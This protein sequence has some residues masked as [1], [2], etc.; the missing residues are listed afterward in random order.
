MIILLF[1]VFCLFLLYIFYSCLKVWLFFKVVHFKRVNTVSSFNSLS[2][3]GYDL[4]SWKTKMEKNRFSLSVSKK[5]I[6]NGNIIYGDSSK[7]VVMLHGFDQCRYDMIPY[8]NYFYQNNFSIVFFDFRRCGES[9][10]MSYSLGGIELSDFKQVMEFVNQKFPLLQDLYLCGH[11]LGAAVAAIYAPHDLRVK[12]LV[13]DTLYSSARELL[14]S[15]IIN[16]PLASSVVNRIVSDIGELLAI[17][18]GFSIQDINPKYSLAR[19]TMPCL[20]IHRDADLSILPSMAVSVYQKRYQIAPTKLFFLKQPQ[21]TS[22]SLEQEQRFFKVLDDFFCE[23]W[24]KKS[25]S[26]IIQ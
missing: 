12:A 19:T 11:S 24:K 14:R 25:F 15:Y 18:P 10:G 8:A 23:D 21:K 6:I 5:V 9:T 13:L 1:L 17:Y 3:L 20:L 22:F 26:Q 16:L 2:A 7:V 4:F